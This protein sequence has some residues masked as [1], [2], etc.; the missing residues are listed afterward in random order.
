MTASGSSIRAAVSRPAFVLL[1]AGD[2]LF[3]DAARGSACHGSLAPWIR[4][5]AATAR[6]GE[7][8]CPRGPCRSA[9]LHHGELR[10]LQ[11]RVPA[12][13]RAKLCALGLATISVV[14]VAL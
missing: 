12:M 11:R 5:V 8:R 1:R 14:A 3:R 7:R 9:T 13:K 2:P 10:S 6:S 4:Y